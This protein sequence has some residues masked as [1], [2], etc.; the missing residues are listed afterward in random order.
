MQWD[1]SYVVSR[2][3]TLEILRN[4]RL[5]ARSSISRPLQDIDFDALPV[6]LAF[7]AGTTPRDALTRLRSEWEFDDDEFA[8][9]VAALIGQAFLVPAGRGGVATLAQEGFAS[10]VAHHHLLQDTVRVLSYQSAIARHSRG[11][12]VVEI[13]CGTGILSIFAARAGARRVVAIEESEIASLAEQMFQANGCDGIIELRRANSRDVELDEP[14][15]LL[16]HE[17][18]GVDPFAE[19]ILPTLLDARER[20]LRPGGRLLPWRVQVLCLGVETEPQPHRDK[21]YILAEAL[22]VQRLY[23]LDFTPFLDILGEADPRQFAPVPAEGD[24]F[25]KSKVLSEECLLVDL[26]LQAGNLNQ[27]GLPAQVHLRIQSRGT[28]GA[29]AVY[30]RADLDEDIQLTNSPFA[31][32]TSWRRQVRPLSRHVEVAP[33]DEVRLRVELLS[34]H[35]RQELDVDLA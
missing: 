33:G 31:P 11:C 26:D 10:A 16:I 7:A 25:F 8:G 28:L 20:L 5:A 30:F 24:R 17:I 27:P 1:A 29:V 21:A 9:V 18:L 23:G 3:L 2:S 6:L 12:S 13:G 4:G 15:D 14:A 32:L 35:G 19:N 22:E 34:R